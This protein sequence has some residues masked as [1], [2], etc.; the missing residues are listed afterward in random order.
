RNIYLLAIWPGVL[1]QRTEIAKSTL[2]SPLVDLFHGFHLS[3]VAWLPGPCDG[4][5]LDHLRR[6]KNLFLARV[7]VYQPLSPP[8][9]E[10][11]HRASVEYVQTNLTGRLPGL[12]FGVRFRRRKLNLGR[13]QDRG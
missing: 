11:V 10:P 5:A 6:H 4:D 7:C 12:Q 2:D 9:P 3:G 8:R 13:V 1:P